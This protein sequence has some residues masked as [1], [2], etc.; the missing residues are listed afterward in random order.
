MNKRVALIAAVA[1]ALIIAV[2]TGSAMGWIAVEDRVDGLTYT[3]AKIDSSVNLYIANDHNRN[4]IPDQLTPFAAHY[5]MERFSFTRIGSKEVYAL[6]SDE[7]DAN[8]LEDFHLDAILPSKVYTLKYE[9]TN[10]SSIENRIS[11][12]LADLVCNEVEARALSCFSVR[13][14]YVTADAPDEL[15]TVHE[16]EKI[17]LGSHVSQG[18]FSSLEVRAQEDDLYIGS[19]ID[20]ADT[21]HYLDMWLS[22]EMES[23]EVLCEQV[24]GFADRVSREQYQALEGESAV[25]PAVYVRFEIVY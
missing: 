9:L 12:I 15:G 1:V 13:L 23:Y 6:S 14:G 7:T 17:F 16:G 18:K 5:Y 20:P 3:V 22:F 11:L 10:R 19:M 21:D 8:M 4:G 24:E 25:I 2:F